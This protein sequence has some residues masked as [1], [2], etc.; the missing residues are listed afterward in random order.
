MPASSI[1]TSFSL[2][3]W[4]IVLPVCGL[5]LLFAIYQ[6]WHNPRRWLIRFLLYVTAIISLT[7][8]GLQPKKT[9]IK[10]LPPEAAILL[11][12]EVENDFL[13]A[14]T[15]TLSLPYKTYALGNVKEP[16]GALQIPDLGYLLPKL[17]PNTQVYVLGNGL[18]SHELP[19]LNDFNAHFLLSPPNRGSVLRVHWTKNITTGEN[20]EVF[21]SLIPPQNEKTKLIL[22]LQGIR[23]DS[24][25]LPITGT[26]FKSS[27]KYSTDTVA[28]HLS[29]KSKQSGLFTDSLILEDKDGNL[30]FSNPLPYRVSPLPNNR[31]AILVSQPSFEI[32][33]LKNH[34]AKRGYVVAQQIA[35]SRGRYKREFINTPDVDLSG[36]AA[37]TLRD[38]DLLILD[39]AIAQNLSES[40]SAAIKKAIDRNALGLLV[41][42]DGDLWQVENGDSGFLKLF[43]MQSVASLP[44]F[45]LKL[46]KAKENIVL[47]S[48]SYRIKP[49]EWQTAVLKDVNGALLVYKRHGL[50]KIGVSLLSDTYKLALSGRG[51]AYAVLQDWVLENMLSRYEKEPIFT[52]QQDLTFVN[53]FAAFGTGFHSPD[54]EIRW[55]MPDSASYRPSPAQTP[56][57][58]SLYFHILPTKAGWHQL[59]ME[60]KPPRHHYVFGETDWQSLRSRRRYDANVQYAQK[61]AVFEATNRKAERKTES[62]PISLFPFYMLLVLA[63]CGLWVEEKLER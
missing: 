46:P 10:Y 7:I 52:A 56:A 13:T 36:L 19:L 61:H 9:A 16:S 4:Q 53:E 54:V 11:T 12:T 45:S 63:L 38:F 15:D 17:K 18:P 28:F 30:L 5:L 60:G 39:Q 21:G 25:M 58:D 49:K 20:F 34:F 57:G 44:Q 50:G 51:E 32:K 29:A 3:N 33:F 47:P 43:V 14:L 23:T 37:K 26:N 2:T 27:T 62:L 24:L 31:I 40:E 48:P 35:I 22:L 55:Q 42:A 1:F 8:I 41:L 6:I 59:Q